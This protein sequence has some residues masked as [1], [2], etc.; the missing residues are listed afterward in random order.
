MSTFD[1]YPLGFIKHTQI[2][3]NNAT[4]WQIKSCLQGNVHREKSF[5]NQCKLEDKFGWEENKNAQNETERQE[6]ERSCGCWWWFQTQLNDL[7]ISRWHTAPVFALITT[8]SWDHDLILLF[9]Q[10]NDINIK[11]FLSGY[12]LH[13]ISWRAKWCSEPE[14]WDQDLM[15]RLPGDITGSVQSSD[16]HEQ[17]NGRTYEPF[18]QYE[19]TG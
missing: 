10:S 2:S 1:K 3:S 15:I 9:W 4:S 18:V 17:S 11:I 12:R 13:L 14:V 7:T 5:T 16:S 19:T 8:L 6:G